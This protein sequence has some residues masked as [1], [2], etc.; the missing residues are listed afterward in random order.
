MAIEQPYQS[1]ATGELYQVKAIEDL[2]WQAEEDELQDILYRHLYQAAL[3]GAGRRSGC[4]GIA[5][6]SGLGPGQ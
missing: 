6:G 5:R 1:P 2:D 4:F 3:R